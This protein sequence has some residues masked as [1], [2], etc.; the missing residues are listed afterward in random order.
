MLS[1][2]SA[3][4][5]Q[6][7]SS[8][9]SRFLIAALTPRPSIS[10][11]PFGL[12]TLGRGGSIWRLRIK[13][14]R[15][16]SMATSSTSNTRSS[17][18]TAST[19]TMRSPGAR[20][21]GCSQKTIPTTRRSVGRKISIPTPRTLS[22]ATSFRIKRQRYLQKR[23]ALKPLPITF[24]TS[25]QE[26]QSPFVAASTPSMRRMGFPRWRNSTK[27]W[28]PAYARPMNS[29]RTSFQGASPRKRN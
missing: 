10:C 26:N 4:A 23:R 27:P 6:K 11:P 8:G 25:Q 1:K 12:G 2:K 9:G 24:S 29:I 18:N 16:P 5:H 28:K 7:T 14:L 15:S 17:V 22:T 20:L 3:N 21:A 19:S 13:S